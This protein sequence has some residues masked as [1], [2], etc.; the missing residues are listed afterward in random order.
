[1]IIVCPQDVGDKLHGLN[2]F[3]VAK[4]IQLASVEGVNKR[5]FLWEKAK[6]RYT[7]WERYRAR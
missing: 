5:N 6:K 1:M 4:I 3:S 7:F 2:L